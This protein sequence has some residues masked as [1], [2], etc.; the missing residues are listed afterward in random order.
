MPLHSAEPLPS[1]VGQGWG[2]A[3]ETEPCRRPLN[4]SPRGEKNGEGGSRQRPSPSG[5]GARRADEGAFNERAHTVTANSPSPPPHSYRP[6]T[7]ALSPRGEGIG[8]N[9]GA[10]NGERGV[11][12]SPAGWGRGVETRRGQ[13]TSRPQSEIVGG[14]NAGACRV[15]AGGLTLVSLTTALP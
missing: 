11:T 5:E 14:S 6:L 8:N 4:L 12:P 15:C 10:G 1:G 13:L 9:R 3:A 7:L 2:D